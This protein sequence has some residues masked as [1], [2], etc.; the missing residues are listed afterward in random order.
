MCITNF[1]G[2]PSL[3]LR[4]G[5]VESPPRTMFGETRP[6]EV[7]QVPH[8]IT[9]WGRLFDEATLVRTGRAL[10]G[11]LGVWDERPSLE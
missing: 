8:G 11:A 6:G 9:L 10:E 4:A 7:R 2:N 1:T 5:F 3:T